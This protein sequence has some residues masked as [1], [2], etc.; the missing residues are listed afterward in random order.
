[1]GGAGS[2]GPTSSEK[3][4][5][6]YYLTQRNAEHLDPQRTYIGRDIS[7]EARMVYRTLTTFPAVSGKASTKLVPDL[8]TD[9]GTSSNGAK[10]WKFTIKDGV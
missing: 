10:T 8:A 2:Q 7:N 6:L 9:T 4:G 3:G 5:T 1:L